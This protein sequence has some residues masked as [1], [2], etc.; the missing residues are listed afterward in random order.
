MVVRFER[1]ALIDPLSWR[2][3]CA[4]T[5]FAYDNKIR[6]TDDFGP[7]AIPARCYHLQGQCYPRSRIN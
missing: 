6:V 7:D 4:T 2:K 1:V 5:E 3:Y